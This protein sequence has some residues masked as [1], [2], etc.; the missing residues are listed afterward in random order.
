MYVT[1]IGHWETT[2]AEMRSLA[3]Y[4]I[5]LQMLLIWFIGS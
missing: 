2:Y 1:N 5:N 3:L 4:H